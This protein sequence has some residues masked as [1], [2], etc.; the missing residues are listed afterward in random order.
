MILLC[1]CTEG[2]REE[3]FHRYSDGEGKAEC[4]GDASHSDP[5]PVEHSAAAAADDAVGAAQEDAAQRRAL[6]HPGG[7]GERQM[8]CF[9]HCF[10]LTLNNDLMPF[11]NIPYFC[12]YG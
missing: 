10:L 2:T 1:F 4:A 11:G 9:A 6:A 12:T 3:A 7:A 5:E 8:I